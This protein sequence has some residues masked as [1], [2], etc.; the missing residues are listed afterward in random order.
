[1]K[2]SKTFRLSKQAADILDK[3]P[4]ATQ[5]VE[6]LILNKQDQTPSFSEQLDRIEEAV[7]Y[8]KNSGGGGTTTG[9]DSL[10]VTRIKGADGLTTLILSDDPIKQPNSIPE[11][12]AELGLRYDPTFH[13]QAF[14]PDSNSL[15]TYTIKDGEVIL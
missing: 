5:F 2:I 14:D 1:M 12:L 4:N 10:G 15:V 13:N 8:I 3:Q 9:M 11:Q 7:K 6:S